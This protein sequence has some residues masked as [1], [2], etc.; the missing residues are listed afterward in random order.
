M[1]QYGRSVTDEEDGGQTL[2]DGAF[3]S[4]EREV[5]FE[6]GISGFTV[7]T[8]SRRLPLPFHIH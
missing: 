1:T 8:L 4:F 3:P 5:G 2:E 6:P 7:Q